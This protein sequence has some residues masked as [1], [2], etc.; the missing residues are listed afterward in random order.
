MESSHEYSTASRNLARRVRRYGDEAYD[1]QSLDTQEEKRRQLGKKVGEI[2]AASGLAIIATAGVAAN[3]GR[4]AQSETAAVVSIDYEEVGYDFTIAAPASGPAPVAEFVADDTIDSDPFAVDTQA[5]EAPMAI[6]AIPNSKKTVITP[7]PTD[8]PETVPSSAPFEAPDQLPSFQAS[9]KPK[10]SET[11]AP[12]PE[13]KQP[14]E[15]VVPTIPK[16]KADKESKADNRIYYKTK[17]G[18]SVPNVTDDDYTYFSQHDLRFAR[19][20]YNTTRSSDRTIS[21]SGC[22]P[23]TIAMVVANLADIKTDPYKISKEVVKNGQRVEGGTDHQ[24]FIDVPEAHGLKSKFIDVTPDAIDTE[25]KKGAW[26]IVNG[27]DGTL[28]NPDWNDPSTPATAHGHIF[29][30]T[31]IEDGKYTVLDPNSYEYTKQ[32]F[33]KKKITGPASRAVSVINPNAKP[34]KAKTDPKPAAEPDEPEQIQ[35][36]E[37]ASPLASFAIGNSFGSSMETNDD[38]SKPTAETM[39]VPDDFSITNLSKEEGAPTNEGSDITE[40]D[41]DDNDVRSEKPSNT[42]EA[43]PEVYKQLLELVSRHESGGN[44]NAYFSNGRNTKIR[45]TDMTVSEVLAWQDNFVEVQGSK[46]SAIGRYQIIRGT[47]RGLIEQ[48][49]IDPKKTKFDEATQDKMAITLLKRHRLQDFF[50]GK[51]GRKKFGNELAHEWASLPRMTGAY[52]NASVYANDGLNKAFISAD[53]MTK[54]LAK[55]RP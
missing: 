15:P 46:S 5:L 53:E 42:A 43:T 21:G 3:V 39:T 28:H 2:T 41:E 9:P 38:G 33:A 20:P 49:D 31:G 17:G 24:A 7:T 34:P 36:A 4:L 14:D 52:P 27:A 30:I 22:G 40:E 45:F 6:V 25:I 35:P 29:V 13:T 51:I 37:E 8:D 10:A 48:M 55:L 19:K 54:A 18:Y 44:Y 16:P 11:I 1:N 47:M 23:T 12:E 26:V 32:T 50:D